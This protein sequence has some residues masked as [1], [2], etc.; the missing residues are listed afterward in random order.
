MIHYRIHIRALSLAA[1]VLTFTALP[2][3]GCQSGAQKSSSTQAVGLINAAFEAKDNERL[4]HL[5][6]SLGKAG[7]ISSGESNY[8]QGY[9]CYQT[10]Q[11]ESAKSFWQEAIRVTENSTN[12]NDLVYYAKSASYLTSQ[13]CRYAEYAAALYTAL[14]VI[15]RLEKLQC[16]TTSDYT[17]LLIFAGCCKTYFDRGDSTA[18][19]ML[20]R[21]Y[22]LHLDNIRQKSSKYAYRDA[23]AGIINIAYIWN[24]VKG[25]QEGLLWTDRMGDLLKEYKQLYADDKKYIDK[26]WARYLIFHATSLEGTGRHDEAEKAYEEYLQTQFADTREGWTDA[27]DYLT[28]AKRWDEAVDNYYTILEYLQKD[29]TVYSLDNIQRYLLKK[30]RAHQMLNQEELINE[31]ARQICEVLD[32]AITNNR[33]LDASELQSIHQRDMEIVE[34]EARSARQRQI[35]TGLV[36]V[37]LIIAFAVYV[38]FRRRADHKLRKAHDALKTAYD[39]L[40]ETTTVKERMESELRIASDI[41]M[42]MLPEN[43]PTRADHDD[44]Q[45]YASLTPAKE[46][47]GDLFDF[48]F[49]DEKLFFCIGDVSGKGVP[50]SLFMAVTRSAFRTV[51]AHESMPNRIVN[52]INNTIVDMNKT[53][54]FVT[55]FVGVLDLPTGRLRY[56]NAGHDA[57]LLVGAGLGELAC[58]SNIPVGFM[59]GWEYTLQEAQ[60]FTGTTIFL[61]TD[62]LTEAMDAENAQFQME[63]IN[64]VAFRALSNQQQEPRQII[65]QMTEAV[66]QFVGDAEQSDDLTMMAIQYIRLQSNV[67]MRKS[68]VL[69]NDLQEVPRLNAFVE[70]VCGAVGFDQDGTKQIKEAVEEAVVNVMKYAYPSGTRSDVTIEAASNDVRLKF[71][72]IDKGKPFDPTVQTAADTKLS[73][74]DRPIGGMGIHIIRQNMD[75]INYERI[76]NLNVL[77]LRKKIVVVGS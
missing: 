17:N 56:C 28:V 43:F 57:P 13:L 76:D 34:A 68:I 51:S 50:A 49:R 25:Y 74:K 45:L 5:A 38:V 35:Y 22:R 40:E 21:A 54:M 16:D 67:K 70:E 30:Y 33:I 44:V 10:G 7:K 72:I 14:P 31:T 63:R 2:F 48:Y 18:T 58:D 36:V 19:K 60:I 41:Q 29:L 6:D 61:F 62:G 47:G 4:L 20:E 15:N 27:S 55:L 24:Y 12:A 8:W 3:S 52:T 39:Q 75:S 71:T 26:Q 64:E 42:G 37:I 69:P 11:R 77:T 65:A 59:P 73:A 1:A 66:H 32:S 9:A 23:M 46:V 53:N